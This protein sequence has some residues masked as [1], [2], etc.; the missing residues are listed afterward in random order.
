MLNDTGRQELLEN[1]HFLTELIAARK[2]TDSKPWWE[3]QGLWATLGA[4]VVGLTTLFGNYLIQDKQ[5]TREVALARLDFELKQNRDFLA[6]TADLIGRVLT[7]AEDQLWLAE[8]YLDTSPTE[9]K[10]LVAQI[11]AVDKEWRGGQESVTFFFQLYYG[12]NDGLPKAWEAARD[13]V[14]KVW[15]CSE[16]IYID[17]LKAKAPPK[18]CSVEVAMAHSKWRAVA[19][20]LA[21]DYTSRLE[22]VH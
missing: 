7:A 9:R 6:E 18:S 14:S 3:S 19:G 20:A 12:N 2:S 11:N 5:K 13:A 21:K 4:L 17:N 10:Q 8:G 16:G 15:S 22:R 1:E